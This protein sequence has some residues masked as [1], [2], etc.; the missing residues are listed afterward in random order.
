[1]PGCRTAVI[2]Q[3]L[4]TTFPHGAALPIIGQKKQQG[5]FQLI[6]VFNLHTPAQ[7]E[8]EGGNLAEM[9]AIFRKIENL[10]NVSRL[11]GGGGEI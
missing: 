11:G 9:W 5:F 3:Q 7:L 8:N 10:I 2:E 6:S 1:M 4:R